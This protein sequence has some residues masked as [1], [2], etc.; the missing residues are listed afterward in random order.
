MLSWESIWLFD[1]PGS[2]N[3][4]LHSFDI[5]LDELL[6]TLHNAGKHLYTIQSCENLHELRF[7]NRGL[8][9]A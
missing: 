2:N 3:S 8:M 5:N 1:L 4:E 7:S 9:H 6:E